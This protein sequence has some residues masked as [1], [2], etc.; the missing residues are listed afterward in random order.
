MDCEAPGP[1]NPLHHPLA[2]GPSQ[3]L[4]HDDVALF[5]RLE[6]LWTPSLGRSNGREGDFRKRKKG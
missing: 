3:T 1:R 5:G 4:R 2:V 6:K